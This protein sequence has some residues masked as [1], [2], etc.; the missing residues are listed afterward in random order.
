MWPVKYRPRAVKAIARLQPSVRTRLEREILALCADP[1]AG[2]PLKGTL[3]PLRALRFG[4]YRVLYQVH[5]QPDRWVEIV[6]I[7][8]RKE[9]YDIAQRLLSFLL[10]L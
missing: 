4:D 7:A 5:T 10:S 2:K 6:F 1:Y 8:H 3:R 9:V